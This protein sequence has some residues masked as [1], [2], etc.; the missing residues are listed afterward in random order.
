VAVFNPSHGHEACALTTVEEHIRVVK[1]MSFTEYVTFM[2][3]NGVNGGEIVA[4]ACSRIFCT[5]NICKRLTNGS[6]YERWTT[7]EAPKGR[8]QHYLLCTGNISESGCR[9]GL[10]F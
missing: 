8:P 7:F 3:Q 6:G 1:N 5:L 4:F 10:T 2:S 9:L